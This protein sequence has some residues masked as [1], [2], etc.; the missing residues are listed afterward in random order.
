MRY[1]APGN[2]R[3]THLLEEG[4]RMPV[5]QKPKAGTT[6]G[7]R[8]CRPQPDVERKVSEEPGGDEKNR[9]AAEK[10]K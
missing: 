1:P 6:K 5:H 7:E 8:G 4:E 10:L 2:K 9:R 3:E